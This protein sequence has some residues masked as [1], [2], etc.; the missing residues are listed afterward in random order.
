MR[1]IDFLW[2]TT[3]GTYHGGMELERQAFRHPLTTAETEARSANKMW[4]SY[5]K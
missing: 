2:E 5:N 3:G 4:S 1:Y